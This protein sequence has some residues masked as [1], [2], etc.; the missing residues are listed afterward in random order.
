[1]VMMDDLSLALHRRLV[2][3]DPCQEV[4][5]NEKPAGSGFNSYVLARTKEEAER[6]HAQSRILEEPT[7]FVLDA[8]GLSEGMACLD[9][10]SGAG[11]VMRM[12]G[13]RVGKTGRVLGLD[14]DG[15][16][17]RRVADQLNGTGLSQF[18]FLE[19]DILRPSSVPQQAFSLTFARLLF[20]HLNDPGAALR[21]MWEW[22][23]PGGTVAVMDYDFHTMDAYPPCEPVVELLRVTRAVLEKV[24]GDPDIGH[25]L[26]YYFE[27]SGIGSPD[28][29]RVTG[30]LRPLADIG[31]LMK[32][33]YRSFL[34]TALKLGVTTEEQ[35]AQFLAGMDEAI[36]S[37]SS[38]VLGPLVVGAWKKKPGR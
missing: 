11:D 26:P 25:K 19:G 29:I 22:T 31:G 27:R 17:G 23:R 10:G 37:A 9:V 3:K 13:E 8:A 6:L 36:E 15:E 18:D 21:Q 24:G 20:V 5:M 7:Q 32:A 4:P 33:T 16:L 38:Y 1:M 34:P 2:M 35:S 30:I 14:A 28:G 12:M